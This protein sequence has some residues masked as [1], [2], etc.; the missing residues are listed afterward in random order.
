MSLRRVSVIGLDG[1]SWPILHPLLE[2][3]AMP[4][5]A[6]LLDRSAAGTLR[7]T[8]P[9]YTPPAWTSA[10]TGV[11]PGRHGIFGFVTGRTRPRLAHWNGIRVPTFAD[12]VRAAGGTVGLFHV[13]LTYPPPEVQGWC[14][15]AAWM[16]IPGVRALTHPRSLEAEIRSSFPSYGPVTGVETMVDWRTPD[17]AR[18]VL[19]DLLE[20]RAVLAGLL[21]RRPVDWVWVVLE[22]PDRLQHIYHKYLDPSE[23][24]SRNGAGAEVRRIAES[25]FGV[26]DAIIGDLDAYAGPDGVALVCSDHGSTGLAGQ[27]HG[28]RLL[29]ELSLQQLNGVGRLARSANA[30]LAGALARRWVP[31]RTVYRLR[32]RSLGLLDEAGS[33]AVADRPGSQGFH[34]VP[35][36][37]SERDGDA[38]VGAEWRRRRDRLVQ[39]LRDVRG[40]DG[41]PAFEGVWRREE[42][43]RGPAAALGPDV[44]VQAVGSRW[45]V[46]DWSAV[47]SPF[48]DLSAL[49][50]GRH[51][52]EGIV[53][54]RAAG[55]EP[56][57]SLKA[58]IVD[59][60]PTLLDAAGLAGAEGL[61]GLSRYRPAGRART[62][63]GPSIEGAPGGRIGSDEGRPQPWEDDPGASPYTPE[64]EASIVRYLTSLGYLG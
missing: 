32:R 47:R 48:R 45:E 58:E 36:P 22:A 18:K 57:A 7:S 27:I 60:L 61:D 13:P 4:N 31:V 64:E 28:N 53:A 63:A 29:Q 2:R 51:H 10:L 39:A 62:G 21:E 42:L 1:G 34:V 40:P 19:A 59:V 24:A 11:G 15:A 50:L 12:H 49:P 5:L 55:V 3:G 37:P 54:L 25:A 23:P 8:I 41:G 16:P 43:Y 6:S 46:T 33:V 30:H 9:A 20:R 52:P 56:T 44:V 35:P 17:V 26:M 14:V 38:G